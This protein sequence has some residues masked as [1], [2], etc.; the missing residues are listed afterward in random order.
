M[1]KTIL[2]YRDR[3]D[4]VPSMIKTRKENNVIG[5][6]CVVYVKNDAKLS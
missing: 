3:S 1:P 4:Q 5:C 2:I 6:T